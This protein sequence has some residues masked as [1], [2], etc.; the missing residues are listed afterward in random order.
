MVRRIDRYIL[1]H[2]IAA[3]FVVTA[4]IGLTIIS[5]NAVEELRDFVDHQVPLLK[6][7][8]YYVYFG[9][10][11]IKS[12][13]P[14]FILLAVLFSVSILARRREL[15]AMKATGLSL[16]RISAPILLMTLLLAG[17]HF[18]YNEYVYP[19]ANQKRLEIKEF[20]IEKKSKR[21]LDRV[22]NVY[23][24]ISKGY[25]Y[26]IGSFNV[27]RREG[28]ELRV[29]RSEGN[30]LKEIL[31]ADRIEYVDAIWLASDGVVRTFDST[32]ETFR[33]FPSLELKDIQE[34]PDDFSKRIGKPEDMGYD[35]LKRYIEL[36]KRT[37]GPYVRESID[38]DLKLAFPLSSCIVVLICIPFAS[39]P[40]RG[41][42]AVSFALGTLVSLVYF[43]MFRSLQSAGYNE[44]VPKELA[45]WG[46]NG[47]FFLIG[48]I[49]MWRARK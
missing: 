42:I 21:S 31:T 22:H 40:R 32:G 33:E 13:F 7:L 14:M 28:N 45:V 27:E 34:T 11:V 9:G 26:T 37:G 38:L 24:Q 20:T 39:N 43:V 44:K 25:F 47:L 12:F 17:A 3:L 48:I 46:V 49:S 18:W 35:E 6:I 5:I 1:K 15:L 36:M 19:P 29:Y 16:Y 8:E 23:R 30:Q 41:G 10:W 2:F 4:A